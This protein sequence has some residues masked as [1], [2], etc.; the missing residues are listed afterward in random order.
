MG[1]RPVLTGATACEEFQKY[2]YLKN[3]LTAFC[4]REGLSSAGSKDDLTRRIARYLKTGE[5][6]PAPP[7][8]KKQKNEI[9]AYDA[10]IGENFCCSENSRTFFKNAIGKRFTF[11]TA[12]QEWLKSNPEKTYRDAVEAYYVLKKQPHKIGRQFEYNTYIRDF[13][14]ANPGKTLADAIR[15]WNYKKSLPGPRSYE[16]GDL[17]I[18]E[19]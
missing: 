17:K 4:R 2:Y 3:E 15:C 8:R 6:E 9:I 11:C 19:E 7:A 12:F 1:D 13:F 14:A 10:Q 5:K 18:L 16:T